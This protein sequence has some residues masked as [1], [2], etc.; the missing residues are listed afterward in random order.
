LNRDEC[1]YCI[2]VFIIVLPGDQGFLKTGS[3]VTFSYEGS[4]EPHPVAITADQIPIEIF[5]VK[6]INF[7][8]V[9]SSVLQKREQNNNLRKLFNAVV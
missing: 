3:S 9:E 8:V 6:N 4:I 2:S 7:Q 1:D 5:P